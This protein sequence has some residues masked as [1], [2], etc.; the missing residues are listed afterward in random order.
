MSSNHSA[1]DVSLQLLGVQPDEFDFTILFEDTIL[2]IVP[3][4]LLLLA[5]PFRIR[6]LHGKPRK[7]TK[8]FLYENKLVRF[9]P[10]FRGILLAIC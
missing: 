10:I 2:S 6:A 5:L 1:L 9:T 4:V 8:S 3:S 7:V